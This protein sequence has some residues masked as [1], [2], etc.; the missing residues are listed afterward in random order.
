MEIQVFHQWKERQREGVLGWKFADGNNAFLRKV[1]PGWWELRVGGKSW[2]SQQLACISS[3]KPNLQSSAKSSSWATW[4]STDIDGAWS[5]DPEASVIYPY[6]SGHEQPISMPPTLYHHKH[7]HSQSQRDAFVHSC[8]EQIFIKPSLCVR[9]PAQW[10]RFYRK[11][12]RP[13]AS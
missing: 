9:H 7:H 5:T 12:G 4:L 11:Q 10:Y 6:K 1:W 3:S 2:V 13:L 8:I